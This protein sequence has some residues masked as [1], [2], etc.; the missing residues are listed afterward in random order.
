MSCAAGWDAEGPLLV[1]S[2]SKAR[3]TGFFSTMRQ[4][5]EDNLTLPISS[6][7]NAFYIFGYWAEIFD[8][9]RFPSDRNYLCH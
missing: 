1:S 3:R 8:S 6:K 9:V 4:K 5:Q 2:F 7:R